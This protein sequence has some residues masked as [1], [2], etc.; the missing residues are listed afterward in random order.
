MIEATNILD[1]FDDQLAF[2]S[3]AYIH[4]RRRSA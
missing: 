1:G 4:P 3:A 2:N